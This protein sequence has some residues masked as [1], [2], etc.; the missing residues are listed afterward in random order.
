MTKL[1]YIL[2]LLSY[3][4]NMVISNIT[5]LPNTTLSHGVPVG[6]GILDVL[7]FW[8]LSPMAGDIN[9]TLIVTA[10]I[11]TPLTTTQTTAT[12]S[13]LQNLQYTVTLLARNVGA[14]ETQLI[15]LLEG[16]VLRREF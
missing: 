1:Y 6:L 16:T 15:V 14:T 4:S 12:L 5:A 3:W 11:S 2:L 9:Y 7:L 13:L 10:L 8:F